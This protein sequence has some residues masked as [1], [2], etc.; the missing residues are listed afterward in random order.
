[1]QFVCIVIVNQKE[2]QSLVI[3]LHKLY[4]YNKSNV[5]MILLICL[6]Q[7]LDNC[8]ARL[9]LTSAAK[10]VYTWDKQQI[11]EISDSKYNHVVC[12]LQKLLRRVRTLCVVLRLILP[13]IVTL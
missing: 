4:Q 12:L 5:F 8:T 11:T 3:L 1:M 13:Y 7:F 2:N 10:I 9:G 6:F